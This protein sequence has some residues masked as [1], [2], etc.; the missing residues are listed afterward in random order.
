MGKTILVMSGM[1]LILSACAADATAR[2][3]DT[4]AESFQCPRDQ[5]KLAP[6]GNQATQ[7]VAGCGKQETFTWVQ[8]G[9]WI[10]IQNLRKRASFDLNCPAEQLKLT[11]LS[12]GT[13]MGVEGCSHRATYLYTTVAATERGQS[14]DWVMNTAGG[15]SNS[16]KGA[17]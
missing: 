2:L 5:L 6:V 15:P 16:S 13:N 17:E 8:T 14:Y 9:E 1:A 4:A 7:E 12:S 10:Q 3:R 11:P